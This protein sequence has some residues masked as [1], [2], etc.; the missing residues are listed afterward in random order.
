VRQ[1]AMHKVS[2]GRLWPAIKFLILN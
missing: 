2:N 1:L